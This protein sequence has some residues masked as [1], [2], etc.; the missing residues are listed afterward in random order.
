M[1]GSLG[2]RGGGRGLCEA[3]K[4]LRVSTVLWWWVRTYSEDVNLAVVLVVV[5]PVGCEGGGGEDRRGLAEGTMSVWE[6]GGRHAAGLWMAECSSSTNKIKLL[7]HNPQQG[8]D[9]ARGDSPPW[10]HC[11]AETMPIPRDC[12]AIATWYRY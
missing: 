5:G 9:P 4:I 8:P 7:N 6:R 12:H 2:G 3:K 1:K 11:H 10:C